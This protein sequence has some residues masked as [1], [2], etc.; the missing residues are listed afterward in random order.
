MLSNVKML[1]RKFKIL[2]LCGDLELVGGIEKYNNDFICFLGGK[3]LNL[4]VIER[5][6]GGLI[7]KIFFLIK[8]LFTIY[9]FKPDHIICAH[10]HFSPIPYFAKTLFGIDYSINLYGIEAINISNKLYWKS[11]DLSKYLIVISNYTKNLIQI[12][13]EYP[14]GK[15][16]L[17]P[18]SVNEQKYSVSRNRSE[19]KIKFGL[20]ETDLVVLTISRLS[21][22]EE[23]GQHRVLLALTKLLGNLHNIKYLIAGPGQD[24]RVDRVMLEY[25][26]LEDYVVRL[27]K[28]NEDDKCD[29]INACDVF[30][31]PSKNEGFGI[32]F[33]EALACGAPVIASNGFGCPEGLLYGELGRVVDPDDIDEIALAMRRSLLESKNFLYEDRLQKRALSLKVY[34]LAGMKNKMNAFLHRIR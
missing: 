15:Y 33:I 10:L 3:E 28:I 8:S 2:Y 11:M 6:K 25:P 9:T 18:S 4:R 21:N 29:L 22:H 26:H 32:V 27:G 5:K 14:D 19:L 7:K 13:H 17:L 34:G 30:I 20:K 1:M 24:S 12:Q 16:F 23:K 31:L